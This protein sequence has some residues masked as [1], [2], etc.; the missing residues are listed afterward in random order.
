MSFEPLSAFSGL[1]KASALACFLAFPFGFGACRIAVA[2]FSKLA[3]ASGPS[4][5]SGCFIFWGLNLMSLHAEHIGDNKPA[6]D[7]TGESGEQPNETQPP[8]PHIPAPTQADSQK[9]PYH[10][11]GACKQEKDWW[12][13]AKPLVEIVGV[14]LLSIY[15][16]YTIKM[17]SP[18]KKAADAAKESSHTSAVTMRLDEKAWLIFDTDYSDTLKL[19]KS[20]E[21]SV[22]IQLRDIGKTPARK[23]DGFVVVEESKT[24]DPP[25]F[26]KSIF[27]P[28][29]A[30][31]IWPGFPQDTKAREITSE[32]KPVIVTSEKLRQYAE[33]SLA[34]VVWGRISYKDIFQE[35]HWVQFCHTISSKPSAH[36]K[37]CADYNELD[38]LTSQ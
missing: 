29:R 38:T 7:T 4:M 11:N 6:P 36:S 20:E 33:G 10:C 32:R 23:I 19:R 25:R 27:T 22:P 3:S 1:R 31:I 28:L 8:V 24:G 34:F 21:V 5:Y 13:K 16:L 12:D 2:N 35:S 17:Y 30:G 18:N 14:V 9:P 26:D 37:Q 15:T